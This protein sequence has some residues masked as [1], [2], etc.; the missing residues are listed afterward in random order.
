MISKKLFMC[1]YEF[2]K[3]ISVLILIILLIIK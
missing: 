3:T 1:S 2:D